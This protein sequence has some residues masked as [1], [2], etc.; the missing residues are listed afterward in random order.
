[1]YL[2]PELKKR[3]SSAD[4]QIEE[5]GDNGARSPVRESS[6]LK[7]SR[8]AIEAII[9]LETVLATIASLSVKSDKSSS[10]I[11][12]I[13]VDRSNDQPVGSPEFL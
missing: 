1:M 10:A 4:Y 11:R 3:S 7:P 9:L 13:L 8:R 6:N 12:S 2:K 5:D